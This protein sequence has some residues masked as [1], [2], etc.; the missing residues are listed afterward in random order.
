M[1]ETSGVCKTFRS[2]RGQVAA[3]DHISLTVAKGCFFVIAGRS[4]SGKTTLL[5]CIGTLEKP[6]KGRITCAGIDVTAL[7]TR[8]AA[9]F[10]RQQIG[11]VF[12]ASNLVSYLT[13]RENIALPLELNHWSAPAKKKRVDALLAALGISGL[14]P[15][16]PQELSGGETQRAAFA[17]AIAHA[18][19]ILLADEPTASLD[20]RAGD[21]LIRLMQR[22]VNENG[23]TLIVSTHDPDIIAAADDALYLKDGRK[24]DRP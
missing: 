8:R 14:G 19:P 10:R 1:I 11:F 17:R 6:G 16:M 4:G 20:S 9:E 12:Q 21:Q 22:L 13:V 5:N 2:G 24:E 15:A 18:P 7:S 3:L 23:C